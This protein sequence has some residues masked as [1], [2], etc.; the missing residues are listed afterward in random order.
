MRI[1]VAFILINAEFIGIIAEEMIC[2]FW[3]YLFCRE[4]YMGW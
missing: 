2:G 4:G 3:A 1:N